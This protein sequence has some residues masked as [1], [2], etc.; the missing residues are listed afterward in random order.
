MNSIF[1]EAAISKCHKDMLKRPRSVREQEAIELLG[2]ECPNCGYQTS[3]W[4]FT[5]LNGKCG[6]CGAEMQLCYEKAVKEL[7]R[8]RISVT[9]ETAVMYIAYSRLAKAYIDAYKALSLTFQAVAKILGWEHFQIAQPEIR[10]YLDQ[11]FLGRLSGEQRVPREEKEILQFIVRGNLAH[12]P[13]EEAADL[14]S[15]GMEVV[16]YGYLYEVLGASGAYIHYRNASAKYSVLYDQLNEKIRLTLAELYRE[17][18]KPKIYVKEIFGGVYTPCFLLPKRFWEGGQIAKQLML[19]P[20]YNMPVFP[21]HD[22][23]AVQTIYAPLGGGKTFLLSSIA[24]YSILNKKSFVFTPLNDKTNSFSYACLPLFPYNKRT[25]KLH[26]FLNKIMQIE[27]QGVP[28]LT[29]NVLAKGEK[30]WDKRKHPPTIYDLILEVEKPQAFKVDFKELLSRLKEV[31]SEYGFSKYV[32]IICVRNLDRR[33]EATKWN[34]DYQIATNMLLEFDGWRKR[35]TAIRS[36]VIIDEVSYL[37][38]SQVVLYAGDALRASAAISDIIKESRRSNIAVD[39]ATQAPLE[40]LPELRAAATNIFFRDLPKAKEKSRSQ[41][42]YL[43]ESL[44][45]KEPSLASIVAEMN[46][47]GILGKRYWFW[48]HEPKRTINIVRPTP[49]TFCLQDKNLNAYEI[50]RKYEKLS[51]QKVLL[52]DWTLVPKI[53]APSPHSRKNSAKL[54]FFK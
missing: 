6:G 27:P 14:I 12:I 21:K 20:I 2:A 37:A 22:F 34:L 33:L 9:P 26:E 18:K 30:I 32:G 4:E 51:G 13:P 11:Y 24:C 15:L 31:D 52:E 39:L 47:R 23:G 53:Q 19:E 5:E 48:Y 38:S 41:I 10:N 17:E 54:E 35:H 8:R 45:L 25:R 3:L 16:K 49:P 29:L 42:D 7:S 43:L 36:R 1:F 28:T 40:I 46:N 44:K 50:F